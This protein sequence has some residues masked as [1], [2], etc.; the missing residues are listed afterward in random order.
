[1]ETRA[2]YLLQEYHHPAHLS[3]IGTEHSGRQLVSQTSVVVIRELMHPFQIFL[4]LLRQTSLNWKWS[5]C[6]R[7]MMQPH[8]S[9]PIACSGYPDPYRDQISATLL[10]PCTMG[11]TCIHIWSPQQP[12]AT[13]ALSRRSFTRSLHS[14]S[15]LEVRQPS[16]CFDAE[17]TFCL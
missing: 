11:R 8:S 16:F 5:H 1:M 6:N 12:P 7:I 2:V 3:P 10:L 15:I 17:L 14:V 13:Q 4:F 9:N